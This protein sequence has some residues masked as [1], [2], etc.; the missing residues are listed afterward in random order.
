M[1]ETAQPVL[2]GGT[3]TLD[4]KRSDPLTIGRLGFGAMRITE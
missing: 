1:T 2:A 4:A 3:F